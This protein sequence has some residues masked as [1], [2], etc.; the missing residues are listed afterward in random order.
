MTVDLLRASY[1]KL[2]PKATPGVDGVTW[3][4][5]GEGLE[6]RL[7]DLHGRVHRGTYRAKP[8]RR[9]YIPKDEHERRPL[10]IAAL[11][12]KIVQ[13]ATVWILEQIYETDFLGFSYGFRPGR[14]PH[15]ALDA[16]YMGIKVKKVNWILDADLRKFLEASTYYT[17]VH[18][19]VSVCSE[20]RTNHSML[21]DLR[22]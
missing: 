11:E 15:R 3:R 9:V 2:N 4:A 22:L 10:G 20:S 5:Y 13:Q 8:A 21:N 7:T 18:E 19:A 1:A 14:S 12:D 16:L 17:P 6:G